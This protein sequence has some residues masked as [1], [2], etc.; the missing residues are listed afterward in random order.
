MNAE[1]FPKVT[2]RTPVGAGGVLCYP[3][4]EIDVDRGELRVEGRAVAIRPKTFALLIYLAQH[5]GRLLARDELVQAVWRDVIVTDDSLVQCVS[6]LRSALGD[7]RQQV[8]RTVPRRGYML[9]L[10][11]VTPASPREAVAADLISPVASS[12]SRAPPQPGANRRSV[13][14]APP[15]IDCTA[16]NLAER[17]LVEQADA[18]MARVDDVPRHLCVIFAADVAGYSRLIS[19]DEVATLTQLVAARQLMARLFAAHRG[20]IVNS[21]GDSVLAEFSTVIDAIQAAIAI[22]RELDAAVA[23]TAPD[24]RV[25]FRIGLQL[26]E[27]MVKGADIY[28]DGVN[29]AA[30]LQTLA[31]PGGIVV[32]GAVFDQIRGRLSIPFVNLGEQ[33][34]KNIERPVT[35]FGLSAVAIAAL[36]QDV[37]GLTAPNPG[38]AIRLYGAILLVALVVCGA[39]WFAFQSDTIEHRL[40]NA[41]QQPSAPRPSR[42]SIAVLPLVSMTDPAKDDYFADGLTEDIIAALGRFTD[43]SVR[44]RNAVFAYKG[45]TPRPEEVGRDLNVRYVLEGSVRRSVDSILVAVHLTDTARGTVLWSEQYQ[46]EPKNIFAV[47]DTIKRRIAGSLSI[48]LTN[49]ELANAAPKVPGSMEAYDL[50]LRGRDLASRFSRTANSE[51]RSMFEAAIDRDPNYPPAYVG[52]GRL[53]LTAVIYGWTDSPSEAL[54]RAEGLGRKVIAMDD[55]N[56][57]AYV[58]LGLTYSQLGEYD[59]AIDELRRAL[60]LN[61]SDVEAYSGLGIALLWAGDVPGAIDALET[62]VQ[63]QP[64]STADQDFHLGTA[65]LLAG[66]EADAIRVFEHSLD[67]NSG[68][69]FI[70]AMLAASYAAAGRSS[71][72]KRQADL[73]RRQ[74]PLVHSAD[75]GSRFRNGEHR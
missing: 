33:T 40:A 26:G 32:S 11:P 54:E 75:F 48:R 25:L 20:R 34:L 4:F 47:Q 62:A 39:T 52:L 74:F 66:R 37:F 46:V 61:R 21:V 16:P 7:Q 24:R 67:R 71:D 70:N 65:Y 63:F 23:S 45:R 60:Q 1:N 9:E 18:T 43:I 13:R 31:D 49:V 50:V 10:Q 5:P 72:A 17:I 8:I 6:E 55:T 30:R 56:V 41:P 28:G 59:R 64:T 12:E 27:V 38:R 36:P 15:P 14:C 2:A 22:Q 68:D 69:P 44:S 73:V 19:R 53:D 58:L 51:A 57:G 35:A 29:V 42:Q 3:G